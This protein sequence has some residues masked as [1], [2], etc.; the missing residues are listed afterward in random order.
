MLKVLP[1]EPIDCYQSSATGMSKSRRLIIHAVHIGIQALRPIV[2][3]VGAKRLE[4]PMAWLE[5]QIKGML[6]DCRMCGNC[7]LNVTA[8]R[9]PARCLKGLRNGPCG[10]VRP[11]GNCEVDSTVPCAWSDIWLHNGGLLPDRQPALEHQFIGRS[12]WIAEALEGMPTASPLPPKR[13]LPAGRLERDLAS[14]E[15]VITAEIAPGTAANA[16]GILAQAKLIAP[17][18]NAINVTDGAGA[19]TALSSMAACTLLVQ[20]GYTAVLQMTCRDRN[21]IALQSDLLGAT[22]LGIENVLCLTGD[23]VGNGDHPG[24]KPVFDLDAISLLATARTLRDG[25]TF[26]SGRTLTA[27][28]RYFLGAVENPFAPPQAAR[29]QRV[30]RKIDAG[31][32]FLMTQMVYDVPAFELF[33]AEVRRLGLHRRAHIIAGVGLPTS[34]KAVRWISKHVPGVRIPEHLIVQL[35]TSADPVSTGISMTVN[36]IRRL[37]AIEGLAGV[38]LL[39]HPQR[40]NLMGDIVTQAGLRNRSNSSAE[41]LLPL[42]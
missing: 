15:F 38:H 40:L 14:G 36:T 5:R 33:M 22:A 6:F 8:L 7:I 3:F 27:P 17:W 25:G 1:Q 35:E 12:T 13:E 39:F 2:N 18:V 30:Q 31:A 10:G 24:A 9:C 16:S 42:N 32:Q 20:N 11:D 34:P 19:H 37:R 4:K 21:R 28:P 41:T 29:V 23:G 26:L